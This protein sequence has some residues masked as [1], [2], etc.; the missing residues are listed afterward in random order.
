MPTQVLSC[1]AL[2]AAPIACYLATAGQSEAAYPT[3]LARAWLWV[4]ALPW[5]LGAMKDAA[6]GD[7]TLAEL[8]KDAARVVTDCGG[9]SQH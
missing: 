4:T 8:A 2:A 9:L 7:E 3:R 6:M 5:Q 1:A